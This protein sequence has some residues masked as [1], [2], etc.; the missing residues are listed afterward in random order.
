MCGDVGVA[1]DA[2]VGQVLNRRERRREQAGRGDLSERCEYSGNADRDR[3]PD[4]RELPP[5]RSPM[6]RM[7]KPCH[8][9]QFCVVR[10]DPELSFA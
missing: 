9:Y 2:F 1:R 8:E 4:G 10:Y 6:D 5:R 7:L 3:E